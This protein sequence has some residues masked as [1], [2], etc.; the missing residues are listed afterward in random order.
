M[1]KSDYFLDS[2]Y[3]QKAYAQ[4]EKAKL[5][6]AKSKAAIQLESLKDEEVGSDEDCLQGIIAF[7]SPRSLTVLVGKDE[8]LV[9]G[10]NL[11]VHPVVGDRVAILQ[12]DTGWKVHSFKQRS[13]FLARFRGDRHRRSTSGYE[14]HIITA[15][16]DSALIVAAAKNPAFHPRFIDRYLVICQDGGVQPIICIN[17]IDLAEPPSELDAYKNMGIPVFITSTTTSEGIDALKDVL[18]GT[19]SCLVGASGVGKSS[20][21]NAVFPHATIKSGTVSAKTGEGRHTTSATSLY[22]WDEGSF[23]IDTPGIR[24]LGLE[25]LDKSTLRLY[26]SEFDSYIPLCKFA[27]CSHVHEPN[28]G[29]KQA[30]QAGEISQDRYESYLRLM[31]E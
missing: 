26:F 29:V 14:R 6:S 12:V 21:A 1:R 3:Q 19:V 18:R 10:Q 20:L 2:K 30:V 8:M 5:K 23:L 7:V 13:S 4:Q 17:K 27:N 28:C 22:Q 31:N 24:S 9:D 15:N 16:I 25:D 11:T